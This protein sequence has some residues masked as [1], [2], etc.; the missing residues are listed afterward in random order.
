MLLFISVTI[1]FFKTHNNRYTFVPLYV[2]KQACQDVIDSMESNN[3]YEV[4]EINIKD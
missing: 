2:D 3:M 1:R 4:C